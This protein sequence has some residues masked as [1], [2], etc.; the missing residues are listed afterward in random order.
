MNKKLIVGSVAAVALIAV[1]AVGIYATAW[2]MPYDAPQ[3]I[4]YD[5]EPGDSGHVA[6]NTL[7]YVIFEQYGP[8]LIVL[9]IL[10]FGA[11]VGGI[12]VARE[13]IERYSDDNKEAKE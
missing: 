1:L 8:L 4:D 7:N 10:M 6:S 9:G 12:C 13:E 11:I 5:P 3:A 2:D